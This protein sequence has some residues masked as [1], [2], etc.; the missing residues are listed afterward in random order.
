[1]APPVRLGTQA[2][3]SSQSTQPSIPFHTAA[4]RR[5]AKARAPSSPLSSREGTP[6]EPVELSQEY[7]VGDSR[8]SGVR[9]EIEL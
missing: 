3:S 6:A 1:M 9:F 2:G 4:S 5:L 8:T 7:P